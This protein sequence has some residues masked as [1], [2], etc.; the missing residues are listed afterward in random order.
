MTIL[1]PRTLDRKEIDTFRQNIVD[2]A[3]AV[4]TRA[5][6]L[7]SRAT[8]LETITWVAVTSFSNSWVNYGNGY[9]P[10][11]YCKDG[12]GFVHI[13]GLIKDGTLT[14]T[15]FTLP[16]GYRPSDSCLF[17]SM[18]F[19]SATYKPTQVE[20]L[21]DGSVKVGWNGGSDWLSLDGITFY[22]G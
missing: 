7:E 9:N 4:E 2:G 5:T 10:A 12:M 11:A 19:G 21:S 16:I 8:T 18:S 1:I 20:I 22:A 17:A 3:G 6:T 15:A 14:E 13:K